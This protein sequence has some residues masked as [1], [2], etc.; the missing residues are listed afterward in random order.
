MIIY[1]IHSCN[2]HYPNPGR[3][4]W[5]ILTYKAIKYRIT[6]LQNTDIK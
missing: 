6:R 3:Q 4:T 2:I 1:Y 5:Y